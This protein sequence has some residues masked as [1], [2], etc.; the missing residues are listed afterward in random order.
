M[1]QALDEL[2]AALQGEG[3][4]ILPLSVNSSGA[5]A[6]VVI[7]S[8]QGVLYGF[9]VYSSAAAAQ[10]VL[11]IAGTVLPSNGAV[12]LMA[13]PIGAKAVLGVDFG[14]H[15]RAF[16]QGMILACSST[17]TTLTVGTANCLFDVQYI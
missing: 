13:F 14:Q 9:T 16:R 1:A 15:G 2:E 5:Q 8:G 3:F 17:D 6:S 11:L 7:K 10:F 12:P 4:R